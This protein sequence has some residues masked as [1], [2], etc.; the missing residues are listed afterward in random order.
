ME[1]PSLR[2]ATLSFPSQLCIAK[3][4]SPGRDHVICTREDSS[5]EKRR[6]INEAE[7]HQDYA[8]K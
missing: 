2:M 4:Q 1:A 8:H 3:H 5:V 6:N 7:P